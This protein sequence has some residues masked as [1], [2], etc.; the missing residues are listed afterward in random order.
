MNAWAKVLAGLTEIGLFIKG[1]YVKS[2]KEKYEQ[3][4][5]QDPSSPAD[6]F[7]RSFDAGGLRGKSELPSDEAA[8]GKR[9]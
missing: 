2:E 8:N 1:V 4:R 9:V 5:K 7:Q 6:A 3:E